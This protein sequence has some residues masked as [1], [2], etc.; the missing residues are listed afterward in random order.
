MEMHYLGIIGYQMIFK[1]KR[2]FEF[3]K[4]IDILKE[5]FLRIDL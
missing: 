1:A 5:K 4:K 2:L 3:I